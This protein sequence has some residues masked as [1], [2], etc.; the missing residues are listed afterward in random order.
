MSKQ[1]MTLGLAGDVMIG[2]LVNDHLNHTSAKQIWGNVLP[3]LKRTDLNVINLE[4]TLTHSVKI[5]PKTFNFKATPSKVKSLIEGAIHVVNLANNHILD[6]SEEGLLET[7]DT[8]NSVGIQHIGAGKN[9]SEATAPVILMRNGIKLGILGCTDNESGWKATGNHPGTF[10]L[11]VG[12]L[13]TIRHCIVQLRPQVDLLILSMHWGP[14]MRQRPS[15]QFRSFA[16][17]LIETGVD[18]IHGHS[19]HIFQGVEAYRGKLILYDT[20][21]FVDDYAVDPILRNDRS[22][23]FLVDVDKKGIC[24]LRLV[25]T[26]ISNFE[27]N[28]SKGLEAKQ[29]LQRMQQLSHE[30]HTDLQLEHDELVLRS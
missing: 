24:G 27:V 1:K 19:A 5:V 7:L 11:E 15:A 20:G 12:N 21:D 4:T 23:F 6:Y 30:L 9:L 18:L 16:H 14:N 22:F 13:E 3:F 8:L 28:L 29:T 2:R 25:P 10:Y 26:L 17:E